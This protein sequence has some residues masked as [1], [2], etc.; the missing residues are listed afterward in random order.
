M[1]DG[2][3]EGIKSVTTQRLTNVR[4]ALGEILGPFQAWGGVVKI[5]HLGIGKI[6][7]YVP[8]R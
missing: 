3:N 6:V 8:H 7:P 1:T 4:K 2:E 5:P